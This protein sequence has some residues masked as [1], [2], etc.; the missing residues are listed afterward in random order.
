[1]RL[2][3]PLL[4]L[5]FP[6][7]C[8]VCGKLGAWFCEKCARLI[9]PLPEPRCSHCGRPLNHPGM[10]RRCQGEQ[11]WLLSID[12]CSAHRQ[13]I[14]R[15]IHALKYEGM[16]VLSEPLSE[17]MASTWRARQIRC[18]RLIPVPLHPAR[19]RERG[20]NQS[21]L[22]ARSLGRRLD[23]PVDERSL[24]RVRNTPAQVGLT[25]QE[26]RENMLG[27]FQ[28]TNRLDGFSLLLI[29][30]VCTTGATLEACARKLLEAGASSVRALTAARAVMRNIH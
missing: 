20:Y 28:C 22:L 15:V 18:D 3:E 16:A 25:R 7:H 11:S 5:L 29:D 17:V 27:A 23:L 30:D 13:P 10:C 12:S 1:M 8:V 4:D 21:A 19:K 14:R 24:V 26:R 2:F 6:P 9:E